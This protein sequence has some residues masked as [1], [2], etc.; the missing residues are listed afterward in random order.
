[1]ALLHVAVSPPLA[2]D[3]PICPECGTLMRLSRI[4]PT[5]R[6][7]YDL[8]VFECQGCDKTES[9]IVRFR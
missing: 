3:R 2:T 6:P 1:M 9:M 5:E 7:G 8:R 4:E